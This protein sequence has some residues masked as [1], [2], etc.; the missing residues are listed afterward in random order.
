MSLEIANKSPLLLVW[1][2]DPQPTCSWGPCLSAA[3]YQTKDYCTW[4]QCLE[5][6]ILPD[7]Q[8]IL[9]SNFLIEEPSLDKFSLEMLLGV[10]RGRMT[11][12]LERV[13]MIRGMFVFLA[14]LIDLI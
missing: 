2:P 10:R 7:C 3:S 14:I 5:D 11:W 6:N 13:F 8:A 1:F 9:H 4:Q 12:T